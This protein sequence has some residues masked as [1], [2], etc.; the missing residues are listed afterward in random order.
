MTLRHIS[1]V[2]SVP[3]NR[4]NIESET[5]LVLGQVSSCYLEEET[6]SRII[7]STVT[8]DMHSVISAE[9]MSKKWKIGIE[10]A[11]RTMQVTTQCGVRTAM[12]PITR[13][14]RVDHLQLHKNRLNSHFYGN[15]LVAKTKSLQ[16][17]NGAP[18]Y[19]NGKF[20]AIYPWKLKSDV[21]Q[22]LSDFCADVGIPEQLTA[23][24]AGEQSG[25]GTDFLATARQL[26]IDMH[27]TEKG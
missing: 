18:V 15:S 8:T 20:T 23:D 19:T 1:K 11:K 2:Q 12:H 5:D 22:I 13:R 10:T 26:R 3:V 6:N 16:G 25:L 27:W 24:L 14:Y 9:N 21:G 4:R 7:A 17:N